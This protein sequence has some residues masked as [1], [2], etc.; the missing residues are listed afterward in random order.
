MNTVELNN[1]TQQF[2]RRSTISFVTTLNK[3]FTNHATDFE[4]ARFGMMVVCI[5]IQS[6]LAAIAS[7]YILK[8]HAGDILLSV[9]AALA[10]ASNAVL[11]AQGSA[12]LCLVVFYLSLLVNALFIIFLAS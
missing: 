11:I 5:L 2:N 10:M 7:R 1:R 4:N 3:W 8:S 9:S 6:C 12:K